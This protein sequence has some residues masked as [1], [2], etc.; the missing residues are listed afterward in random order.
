MNLKYHKTEDTS[1]IGYSAD[2]GSD[3]DNRHST[4]GNPFKLPGGGGDQLAQQEKTPV[5][6]LSTSEA[7][8]IALSL[9]AQEAAWVHKFFFRT[10][11]PRKSIIMM[12]DNQ[13]AIAIAKTQ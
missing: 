1:P 2:W 10:K 7:E 5:V 13:G 9:A 3:Y 8:Y 12:E 6:S 11:I 4:T